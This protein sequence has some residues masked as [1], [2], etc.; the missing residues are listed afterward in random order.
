MFVDALRDISD[1]PVSEQDNKESIQ[2][3]Q[4]SRTFI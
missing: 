1:C 3:L 2:G 4:E